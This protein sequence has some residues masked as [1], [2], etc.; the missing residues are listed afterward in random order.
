MFN[1]AHEGGD[2]FRLKRYN[3][4]SNYFRRI[5]FKFDYIYNDFR[6]TK[7]KFTILSV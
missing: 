7:A 3:I 4:E 1:M 6:I 2:K 5:K